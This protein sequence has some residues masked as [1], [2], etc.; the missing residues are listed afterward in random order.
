MDG[1]I[2]DGK[3]RRESTSRGAAPRRSCADCVGVRRQHTTPFTTRTAAILRIADEADGG[4]GLEQP[5]VGA[6]L[7][8]ERTGAVELQTLV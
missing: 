1:E 3:R 2:R 6:L 4:G 5:E 8:H 7:E